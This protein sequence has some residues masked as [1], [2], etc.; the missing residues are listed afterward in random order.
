[1]DITAELDCM[2]FSRVFHGSVRI[3][4]PLSGKGNPGLMVA[5]RKSLEKW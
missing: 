5:I 1:M 2:S 4:E 3:H